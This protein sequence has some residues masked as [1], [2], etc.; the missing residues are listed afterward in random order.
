[1]RKL[2]VSSLVAIALTAARAQSPAPV[3]QMPIPVEKPPAPA[4]GSIEM[5]VTGRPGKA[6]ASRFATDTV[7]IAALDVASRTI[8]LKRR[9][10]ETK[11]I[12]VGPDVTRLSEFAVGDVIRVDYEQ[13]LELEYQPPDAKT[14]PMESGVTAGRADRD[15]APGAVASAGVQGTVTVTAIDAAARLVSF[16]EPGG[17]AYQVKA[18][19]TVHLEKLKVGDRL[20]AT[21]VETVAVN[22]VKVGPANRH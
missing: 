8:T 16:Q 3:P 14:V 9:S 1:M 19:P 22:L 6:T 5:N 4:P 21:Y 12:R 17:N 13:G 18:G 2:L 7:T 15:R 11:T 10:G 20:L